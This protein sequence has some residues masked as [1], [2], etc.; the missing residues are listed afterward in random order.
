MAQDAQGLHHAVLSPR[1]GDLLLFFPNPVPGPQAP[2]HPAPPAPGLR[3]VWP[4]PPPTRRP[5][6]LTAAGQQAAPSPCASGWTRAR[7]G[8]GP[9]CLRG[10]SPTSLPHSGSGETAPRA[11]GSPSSR[12]LP[13]I[14]DL[15]K[16]RWKVREDW[17]RRGWERAPVP[18]SPKP[19]SP[20]P[21]PDLSSSSGLSPGQVGAP[22]RRAGIRCRLQLAVRGRERGGRQARLL[23]TRRPSPGRAAMAT[24][25]A[26]SGG[27]GGAQAGR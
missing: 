19:A 12:L 4:L 6:L 17:G 2:R 1:A 20:R 15:G 10:P 25:E 26:R 13:H 3:G 27:D 21:Q 5:A 24:P 11:A 7:E 14:R 8:G 18:F 23:I 16:A 22:A 9:G